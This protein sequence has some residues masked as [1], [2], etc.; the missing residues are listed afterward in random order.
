MGEVL[1]ARDTQLER[2]VAYKRIHDRHASRPGVLERFIMEARI[3]AMLDH[4]HIVPVYALEPGADGAP[5]YAMKLVVGRTLEDVL[6]ETLQGVERGE[7]SRDVL[8]LSRRIEVFL[9]VCDAVHYA[10]SKGIIHRDL[11][12]ANIMLGKHH[13]VY[14]MDWGLAKEIGADDKT[15]TEIDFDAVT[16]AL[17]TKEGRIKGTPEYMSPEQAQGKNRELDSFSDQFSLGV[18]LREVVTLMPALRDP[19]PRRVILRMRDADLEPM[20]A[21]PGQPLPGD[22]VAIAERATRLEKLE[23]YEDVRAMANDLRRWL[24]GEPTF[25]NPDNAWRSAVRALGRHRD[26]ALMAMLMLGLTCVSLATGAALFVSLQ[27]Q[28]AQA[29]QQRLGEVMLEV[30]RQ[31]AA[32]DGE[33]MRLQGLLH[34]LSQVAVH[35]LEHAQPEQDRPLYFDLDFPD[36]ERAPPDLREA[37]GHSQGVSFSHPVVRMA[38]GVDVDPLRDDIGRLVMLAPHFRRTFLASRGDA[39]LGL[40][41]A[42]AKAVLVQEGAPIVGA[43]IALEQG[44]HVSYP[45]H[46]PYPVDFDPRERPWYELGKAARHPVWGSPHEDANGQGLLLVCAAPLFGLDREFIGVA[47][48]EITFDT[49]V[50]TLME[51]ARLRGVGTTWLLDDEARV[52]LRSDQPGVSGS[53]PMFGVPAVASAV[54]RDVPGHRIDQGKLYAWAQLET[55]GWW[56]VVSGDVSEVQAR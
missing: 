56:L 12:P 51:G 16:K 41:P 21:I 9:N 27:E 33:L 15:I 23:R 47:G 38:P 42:A 49:V 55:M 19:D 53:L 28:N 50:D 32:A 52:V 35:S 54:Q 18:I 25:A 37:K 48:I 17:Q 24:E 26:K 6:D 8:T 22:L 29:R 36:P 5:A 11:K 34:G 7:R 10:H 30:N 40:A 44:A 13:E 31:A 3:T 43:Y 1:R 14:V 39:A 4:P 45:G 46:G 2:E 20:R